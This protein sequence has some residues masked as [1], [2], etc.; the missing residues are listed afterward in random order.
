MKR[1]GSSFTLLGALV[2]LVISGGYVLFG[3]KDLFG[4]PQPRWAAIIFYPGSYV[5]ALAWEAGAHS[6]AVCYAAGV[7][8]MTVVGAMLGLFLDLFAN[9]GSRSAS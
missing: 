7:A 5:G 3:P 8:T 2:A 4:F 1:T 9:I 6:M